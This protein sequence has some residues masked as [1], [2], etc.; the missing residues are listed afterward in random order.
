MLATYEWSLIWE[1]KDA[2][3][4]GLLTALSVAGRSRS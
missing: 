1:N 3:W 2:F 4:H